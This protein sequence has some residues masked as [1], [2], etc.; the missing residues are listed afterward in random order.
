MSQALK[1]DLI[2]KKDTDGNDYYFTCPNIP[3]SVDLSDS[4]I[5]VYPWEKPDGEAG[6]DLVIKKYDKKKGE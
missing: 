3:A 5:F 1:L 6:A 2:C 4:V